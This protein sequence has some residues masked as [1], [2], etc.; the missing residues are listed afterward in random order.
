[1]LGQNGTFG[2]VG[3]L[4]IYM[5]SFCFVSFSQTNNWLDFAEEVKAGSIMRILRKMKFRLLFHS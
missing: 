4:A 2:K 3:I 1:M 5:A